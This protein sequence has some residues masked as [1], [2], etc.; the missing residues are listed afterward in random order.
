MLSK[1]TKIAFSSAVFA[2]ASAASAQA[3][4]VSAYK[5]LAQTAVQEAI[6]GEVGD[7]AALYDVLDQL[8]S[9]GVDGARARAGTDPQ[10]AEILNFTAD[11]AEEMKAM[12]LDTVEEAWHDY[13]AY[14]E[15][16]IDADA[17]DHFGPVI[18]HM[19]AII[20][21][22]TAWIALKAYEQDGDSDHLEQIV[23]ELSEVLE[24]LSHL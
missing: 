8:I 17:F 12:D 20:H 1:F 13:G 5:G 4:S 10:S 9:M 14:E 15:A 18:S 2:L 21:P 3:F 24:H 7:V 16:G 19:D 22:A 6:D 11:H 23:D